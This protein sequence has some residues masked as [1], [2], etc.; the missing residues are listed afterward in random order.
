VTPERVAK[1]EVPQILTSIQ[2]NGRAIS[3]FGDLHPSFAGNVVKAMASAKQ[4]YPLVSRMLARGAPSRPSPGDLVRKLDDELRAT[5]HAVHRL[6]PQIVEVVVHAPMAARVFQPGQF[7]R[8]QNYE[9]LAAK[10]ADTTL[11]MEGLALTGA[12]VNH[13]RGLLSTIVL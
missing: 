5:V 13:A 8:L 12:A 10:T 6:T 7:Y 2:S 4:G 1:P 9:T 11:G 3:F